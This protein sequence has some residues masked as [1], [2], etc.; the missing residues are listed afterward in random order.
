[1]WLGCCAGSVE[2]SSVSVAGPGGCDPDLIRNDVT[3]PVPNW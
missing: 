3:P 1:M 2:Y